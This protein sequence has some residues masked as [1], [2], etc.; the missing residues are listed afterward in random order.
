MEIERRFLTFAD[1]PES[2]GPLLQVEHRSV[3]GETRSFV[4]GYAA[5]FGVYSLDGAVG[6]FVE[7]IAPGAF[8]IVNEANEKRASLMCKALWNHNDDMPLAAYP[9]TLRLWQDDHGLGFEFPVSR[10]SYARDLQ[11]NIEDKIVRGNSFAFMVDRANGGEEWSV[12]ERGRNIR[13]VTRV[14]MVPDVGPCTYPAY[15]EGDLAVAKRSFAAFAKQRAVKVFDLSPYK[16]RRDA[17]TKFLR[18][19]GR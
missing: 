3:D 12:D 10:A 4:K 17:L 1:A 9:E 14:L 13:T 5:R 8:N 6:Q 11:A 19:N 2:E 15:G 16:A 18:S 7:R